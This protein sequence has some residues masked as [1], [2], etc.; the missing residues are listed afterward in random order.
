MAGDSVAVDWLVFLEEIADRGD[1]IA[2]RHFGRASLRVEAKA[3]LSPVSEADRAI[4]TAARRIAS[5]RHPELG[6]LG[7]EE[8]E[9]GSSDLRL[10]IDPIDATK[11][12]VRRIPI[13]GTLLAIEAHGEIVAGVVSAPLLGSRWRAARGCGAF[14][15][16]SRLQV[17]RVARLEE[18]Q[19]FHGDLI[20]AREE[21]PPG[22][23]AGLAGRPS[24]ARGFGDFY[25]HVLV[26][27]GSGDVAIDPA[28]SPWDAAPLLLLVEEAGGR[29][30]SLQ[31]ERTIYGG[32]LVTSNGRLHDEVLAVVGGGASA[33]SGE[34]EGM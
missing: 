18:A 9:S 29:A 15:G 32:S 20:G 4:E 24:R 16:S 3:D 14:L 27:Q 17:S 2:R 30:T 33:R 25:Q 34:A 11:N 26:A 7:E 21:A 31:G 13:F 6:V 8:G 12:F 1:E 28:L 22:R 5:E 10:I 19:L 23:L